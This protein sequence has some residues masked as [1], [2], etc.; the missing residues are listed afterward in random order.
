MS[1]YGGRGGYNSS[2][3]RGYGGSRG[4]GGPKPVEVGKEYEVQVTETSRKGDGIARVQGFVIFVAGGRMGQKVKVKITNVGERFAT[5]EVSSSSSGQTQAA[6]TDSK[7][8]P[9]QS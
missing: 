5:A 8:E 2:G 9:A 6:S 3:N 1:S 7:E 4:F